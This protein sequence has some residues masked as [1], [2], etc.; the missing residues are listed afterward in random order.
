MTG[1]VSSQTGSQ[2]R[3]DTTEVLV[4]GGTA[5]RQVGKLPTPLGGLTGVSMNNEIYMIGTIFI[6]RNV[7]KPRNI[8]L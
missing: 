4:E 2:V 5:W 1:G 3:L 8:K 7:S 6:T